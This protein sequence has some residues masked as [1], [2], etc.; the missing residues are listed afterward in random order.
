[1][2]EKLAVKFIDV[3]EGLTDSQGNLK[4]EYTFDG[5]HILPN[6]CEVILTNL[7]PYINE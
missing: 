1:M 3:S 6:G 5:A 7:A 4:K 2:A